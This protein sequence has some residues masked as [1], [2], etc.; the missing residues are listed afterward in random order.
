M[1]HCRVHTCFS[2][3]PANFTIAVSGLSAVLSSDSTFGRLQAIK[4]ASNGSLSFFR[5]TRKNAA[6]VFRAFYI[7][8]SKYV[9]MLRY[10]CER[11]SLLDNVTNKPALFAITNAKQT[12]DTRG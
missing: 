11:F 2:T 10:V 12:D 6:I 9:R 1:Y 7:I 3:V 5:F 4:R 8:L